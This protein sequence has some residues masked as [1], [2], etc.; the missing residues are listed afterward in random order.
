MPTLLSAPSK[1]TLRR[2]LNPN[3]IF[4]PRALREAIPDLPTCIGRD[5]ELEAL[6]GRV[7]N[8]VFVGKCVQLELLGAETGKLTGKFPLRVSLSVEAA[9][10]LAESLNK[11]ADQAENT[12]SQA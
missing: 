5:L 11:L 1:P 8:R 4:L 3:R 9:R 2:R 6:S 7:T 10:V 12:A